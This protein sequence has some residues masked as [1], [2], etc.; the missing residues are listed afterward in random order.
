MSWTDVFPVLS[1]EQ[2]ADYELKVL[3]QEAALLEELCGVARTYNPQTG[4]HLVSTCLFWKYCANNQGEMPKVTRKLMKTAAKKGLIS[5]YAPWDHYVVPLLEGATLLNKER[6]E[7]VFPVYLAADLKFLVPDLVA[8]GC[9]VKLMKSSSIRH[10]PGAMWRFLA[11]EEKDRWVTVTDS[12]LA[13]D[14]VSSVERTET[15]MAAGLGLW[16]VPYIFTS[17]DADH[18]LG[19]YRPITASQIGA[20]GGVL[21]MDKLM[22]AFLWHTLRGTMPNE[23]LMRTAKGKTKPLAIFGTDWPTYGFD[24][25]FLIAVVYPRLA[26]EGVLTFF[27][28]N[29]KVVTHWF[30]LDI[31]Y[32]TW[33]NAKSE[34]LFYDESHLIAPKKGE[35]KK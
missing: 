34:I 30:A 5:R 18:H 23:C 17:I 1:D 22:K 29:T 33:A 27:S 4:K 8:V 31:E 19:H 12:D 14:I 13:R 2:V 28:I 25:W 26:F 11:F 6:P 7:V 32:V 15:I 24:E 20:V 35:R 21:A 3:P 9:E 16:R 10:N